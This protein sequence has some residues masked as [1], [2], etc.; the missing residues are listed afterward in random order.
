[1][2]KREREQLRILLEY[3]IKH[4]SEHAGEFKE[5][6]Q[7][8]GESGQNEIQNDILKAVEYMDK[9]NDQLLTALGRLKENYQE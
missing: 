4:N 7:K 6:A 8:A 5:W 2:E 3:W 9:V 1:M